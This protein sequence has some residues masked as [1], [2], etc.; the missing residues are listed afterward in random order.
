MLTKGNVAVNE[1]LE[2]HLP[3]KVKPTPQ[4]SRSERERYIKQKYVS[5]DF[6]NNPTNV[7]KLFDCT[8]EQLRNLILQLAHDSP[9]FAARLKEVTRPPFFSS[10]RTPDNS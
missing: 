10:I 7:T 6:S 2:Q 4:S 8:D 1:I 5:R 9:D 3:P